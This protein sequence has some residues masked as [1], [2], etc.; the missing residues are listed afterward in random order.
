MSV[1]AQAFGFASAATDILAGTYLYTLP[2]ATTQ[3]LVNKLQR[4]YR[5]EAILHR[6]EIN[7]STS[8]YHHIQEYLAL[9]LPPRIEAEVVRAVTSA[10]VETT[11]GISGKTF[12][13]GAMGPGAST[14]RGEPVSPPEGSLALAIPRGEYERFL[15]SPVNSSELRELLLIVCFPGA[16]SVDRPRFTNAAR[17]SILKYLEAQIFPTTHKPLK[18]PSAAGVITFVDRD[19]L[20]TARRLGLGCISTRPH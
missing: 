14:K 8:A 7:A 15:S 4:Q 18:D 5:D 16:T 2:P 12:S 10:A 3:E 17:A 6:T 19:H 9:C 20:R 13:V 11:P 1:V